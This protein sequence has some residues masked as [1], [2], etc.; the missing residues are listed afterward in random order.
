METAFSVSDCSSPVYPG[1]VL[2]SSL[3]SGALALPKL[4]WNHLIFFINYLSAKTNQHGFCCLQRKPW[5]D[6][7]FFKI[8]IGRELWARNAKV[9][10]QHKHR[11]ASVKTQ[12]VLLEILAD[13]CGWVRKELRT[14][15]WVVHPCSWKR[16][17]LWNWSH[18]LRNR[19]VCKNWILAVIRKSKVVW[20][21][22]VAS[23]WVGLLT[24]S[25][26]TMSWKVKW[27]RNMDWTSS[28]FRSSFQFCDHS[29]SITLGTLYLTFLRLNFLIFL[30]FIY[31]LFF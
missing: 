21:A 2:Q 5:Y 30:L 1:S 4:L 27:G 15:C 18:T 3:K 11:R 8:C 23:H 28:H 31:L 24:K 10:E 26:A 29:L 14:K 9:R 6:F 19:D 20:V 7:K 12:R 22:F 17:T 25:R 13:R 16:V